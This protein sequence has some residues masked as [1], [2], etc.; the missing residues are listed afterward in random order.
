MLKPTRVVDHMWPL[1]GFLCLNF[2][3]G[4]TLGYIDDACTLAFVCCHEIYE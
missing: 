3:T 4:V 1:R 2:G